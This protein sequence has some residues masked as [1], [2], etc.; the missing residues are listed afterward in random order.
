MRRRSG[1]RARH[2][3]LA[4]LLAV[5]TVAR[6]AL[7]RVGGA[8]ADHPTVEALQAELATALEDA[9][10]ARTELE[11]RGLDRLDPRWRVTLAEALPWDDPSPDRRALWAVVRGRLE[12]AEATAALAGGVLAGRVRRFY[13]RL[14]LAK[15]ETLFDAS[16]RVRFA[17]GAPAAAGTGAAGPPGGA[18][19]E[20]GSAASGM[21][22][23]TGR[24]ARGS[25]LLEIRRLSTP[26]ALK[27][28]QPVFTEGGDGVYPPGILIGYVEATGGDGGG[29]DAPLLVRSA[30]TGVSPTLELVADTLRPRLAEAR[31]LESAGEWVPAAARA[32]R[33]GKP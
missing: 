28:G 6:V 33:E 16:F 24:S 25:A 30:L 3:L 32:R 23:G 10:R 13:R 11:M 14:S 18:T 8:R 15:V 20:S 26:T 4:G 27:P 12:D 21:L 7:D 22:C 2:V 5:P 29:G 1:V 17:A 31:A 19:P 9:R